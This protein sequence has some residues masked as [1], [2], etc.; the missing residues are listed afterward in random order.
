MPLL[1]SH[2]IILSNINNHDL[3]NTKIHT[4]NQSGYIVKNT[5]LHHEI[6]NITLFASHTHTVADVTHFNSRIILNDCKIRSFHLNCFMILHLQSTWLSPHHPYCSDISHCKIHTLLMPKGS[7]KI[8]QRQCTE[9]IKW[10]HTN[11]ESKWCRY[12]CKQMLLRNWI[13]NHY[14]TLQYPT[15]GHF[16]GKQKEESWMDLHQ[17]KVKMLRRNKAISQGV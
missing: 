13:I 9:N 16:N 4:V 12:T 1:G 5:P 17:S 8:L 15:H 2:F 6:S 10:P 11:R 7:I 3:Y 14:M